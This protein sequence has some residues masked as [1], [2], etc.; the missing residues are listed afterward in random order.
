MEI[1]SIRGRIIHV[2]T[3][4]PGTAVRL[5]TYLEARPEK[6]SAGVVR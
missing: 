5:E 2:R 6:K 4:N 3:Y 1:N